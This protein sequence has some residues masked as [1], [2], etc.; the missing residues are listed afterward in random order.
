MK[1]F[2]RSEMSWTL[3]SGEYFKYKHFRNAILDGKDIK[4]QNNAWVGF[5][6]L[7]EWRD[8][9]AYKLAKATLR[10][11][12]KNAPNCIRSTTNPDGAGRIEVKEF[13][14]LPSRYN[15]I[16]KLPLVGK[17]TEHQYR[18][19]LEFK[20]K[21]N[22]MLR[23]DYESKL[24]ESAYNEDYVQFWVHGNWD[25]EA[26]DFFGRSFNPKYNI[27]REYS[28]KDFPKGYRYF[29]SF[30]WGYSS[31]FAM[32][33]FA[34]SD[35]TP[36]YDTDIG[37]KKGDLIIFK[38]W[39][40]C[41]PDN[42]KK[43]LEYGV[44]EVASGIK[45]L[46][47]IMGIKVSNRIADPAIFSKKDGNFSV[48]SMMEDEGIYFNEYDSK[49][50]NNERVKGWE[51]VKQLLLAT[52]GTRERKGLYIT[53]NCEHIIRTTSSLIIDPKKLGD[54]LSEGVEDHLWDAIRYG[55]YRDSRPLEDFSFI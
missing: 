39:Y 8:L 31:P 7:S 42:T 9:D 29:S 22:P 12:H 33:W 48:D 46:E 36:L 54:C 6:E 4:G 44:D 38:E 41:N 19:S 47:E 20:M 11:V 49:N 51:C 26:S 55:C 28:Y 45:T 17:A 18:I 16:I 52:H 27:I 23:D 10:S 1:H 14:G 32:V 21:D 2:N 34:V 35:G 53:N 37:L 43:G 30:D 40:G 13:F 5:E 3:D 15:Q 50:G 25:H 24:L